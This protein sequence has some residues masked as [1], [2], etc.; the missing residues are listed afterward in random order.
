MDMQTLAE[1]LK[2]AGY[3]THETA[4]GTL[5]ITGWDD[6]GDDAAANDVREVVRP[7]GF[8]AEWSDDDLVIARKLAG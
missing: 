8:E 5:Y 7:H 2:Q 1:V 3:D 4:T 6:P